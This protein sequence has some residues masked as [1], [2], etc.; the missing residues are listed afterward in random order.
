MSLSDLPPGAFAKSDRSPDLLF[1]REPRFVTHIDDRAIAALTKLYREKLP[2]G[3]RVLDL[4]SSWVSH[5]PEDVR[6]GEVTGHG[7]NAEELSRNPRLD[8]W[9]TQ[10]L[11]RDPKF[12]L[13][14]GAFDAVTICVS[15]QYLERPVEVLREVR[16]IL[17][18]DGQVVLSFSNRCFPTKAVSIWQALDDHDHARLVGLY[19]AE[20]GFPQVEART[21]EPA[22]GRGDPLL[23]VIGTMPPRL[24][25]ND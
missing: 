8:R 22:D 23:A 25:R 18:P 6:Y 14:D 10:D 24:D 15:V 19:L 5:L 21:L 13:S 20:A 17:A 9:F 12:D 11:N 3:A 1:Y 2:A 7:M 4:M 16:R